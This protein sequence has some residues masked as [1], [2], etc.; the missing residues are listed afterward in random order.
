ME[1]SV[2][3]EATVTALAG[4]P[5][6]R[7]MTAEFSPQKFIFQD[8]DF[9]HFREGE[10]WF[11]FFFS[12]EIKNWEVQLSPD[13]VLTRS[14][15]SAWCTCYEDQEPVRLAFEKAS[16]WVTCAPASACAGS[17]QIHMGAAQ[18]LWEVI[19]PPEMFSLPIN[20]FYG[21]TYT[22]LI[23]AG[24]DEVFGGMFR[25]EGGSPLNFVFAL[26]GMCGF[27]ICLSQHPDFPFPECTRFVLCADEMYSVEKVST[28]WSKVVLPMQYPC[29]FQLEGRR[30]SSEIRF[31][32]PVFCSSFGAV[33]IRPGG[34]FLPVSVWLELVRE[35]GTCQTV[36]L[37]PCPLNECLF[38]PETT[39]PATCRHDMF[40]TLIARKTVICLQKYVHF[41]LV[42]TVSEGGENPMDPVDMQA[43]SLESNFLMQGGKYLTF[44]VF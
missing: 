18:T 16:L 22:K 9:D 44:P 10:T 11:E 17:I 1:S 28:N 12:K 2:S 40:E 43:F 23:S 33:L 25:V 30:G 15:L 32:P 24:T 19:D 8:A 4:T 42:V 31:I 37:R 38:L 6:G 5:E 35:D 21:V 36:S 3:L 39:V 13:M 27:H 34:G 7:M 41:S 14:R 26:G 20:G 29:E